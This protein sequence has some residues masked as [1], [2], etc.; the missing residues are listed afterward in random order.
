MTFGRRILWCFGGCLL[1]ALVF[2]KREPS[3]A[4]EAKVDESRI[5]EIIPGQSIGEVKLGMKVNELPSRT[6]I[7]RPA[8]ML[9]DIRLLLNEA[10]EIADIWIEDVHTFPHKLRLRG[11]T[12]PQDASIESL[13]TLF[14]KCEPISGLKG[15]IF[16]NCAI[17]LALG[18]DFSQK[19]LQ[20]RVKHISTK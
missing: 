17:G 6:V 15:G 14:G 20:I 2:C 1:A 9:D 8:G 5:I 13:R 11:K 19:T 18:T 10:G 7:H 4:R 16:Y 12:I 3:A